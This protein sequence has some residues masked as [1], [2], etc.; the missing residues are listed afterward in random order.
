MER[1]A[2]ERQDLY[3]FGYGHDYRKA[4]GDYIHVAGR[5]PLPPRFAF[6]AWWSRY[7]ALQRSGDRRDHSRIPRELTRRSTS[8]SSTWDWHISKSNFRPRRGRQ[9]RPRSIQTSLG[10]TGYTWNNDLFPI[11]QIFLDRL[12]ANR[13]KTSLN[14]HP[15]SGVQ[16]W[17]SSYPAMARA[18]GIDPATK[19]YVPFDIT[20]KKFA[21]KLLQPRPSSA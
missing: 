2:G 8:S 16:P 19:K 6:G 11:P 14:L 1:P 15:A 3:F 18:M 17:E 13:L 5:I 4:L 20:N 10:W 7:W 12:H 9:E 21:D